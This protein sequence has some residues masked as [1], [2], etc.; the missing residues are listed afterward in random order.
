MSKELTF[1]QKAVGLTFNPSGDKR[2][3]D[4]KTAIAHAIDLIH[5]YRT[6][7]AD[8]PDRLRCYAIAITELQGGQMWAV[9]GATFPKE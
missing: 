6:E 1:G 5:S 9:K 2:V 7:D 8:S 3:H 4:I